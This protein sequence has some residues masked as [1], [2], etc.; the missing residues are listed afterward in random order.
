MVF[1]RFCQP[2]RRVRGGR[3]KEMCEKEREGNNN[4]RAFPAKTASWVAAA[5]FVDSHA[6]RSAAGKNRV[7]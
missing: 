2:S 4:G 6:E 3:A 5:F 7:G 1:Q